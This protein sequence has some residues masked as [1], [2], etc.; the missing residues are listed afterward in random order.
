MS[1]NFSIIFFPIVLISLL[2]GYLVSS[3]NIFKTKRFI[4]I[5]IYI[6]AVF[7]LS[8]ICVILYGNPSLFPYEYEGEMNVYGY[9]SWI[10]SFWFY[11]GTRIRTNFRKINKLYT[12]KKI[13]GWLSLINGFALLFIQ[14]LGLVASDSM[15]DILIAASYL[16]FGILLLK[17]Y[18]IS[19]DDLNLKKT[20]L[21]KINRFTILADKT[22]FNTF[23]FGYFSQKWKV[24]IRTILIS[25]YVLY[26]IIAI[27]E[28]EGNSF[29]S[30][31]IIYLF[32]VPLI[33]RIIKHFFI[34]DLE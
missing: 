8:I 24:F 27:I 16:I 9:M 26:F 13:I 6:L 30:L 33:S 31:T 28:E 32:L 34:K 25:L 2:M 15:V 5:F 14:E 18:P 11:I 17:K 10:H 3:T 1:I 29:V 12:L 22:T 4:R 7:V 19:E 23:F 20:V 21:L